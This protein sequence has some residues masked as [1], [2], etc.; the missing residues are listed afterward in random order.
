LLSF[1]F[2]ILYNAVMKDVLNCT[3]S[4]DNWQWNLYRC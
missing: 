3:L 2:G 4:L 1:T